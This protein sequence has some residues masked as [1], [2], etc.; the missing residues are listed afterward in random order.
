MERKKCSH[1]SYETNTETEIKYHIESVH[2]A[3][4][5]DYRGIKASGFPSGH[6]QWAAHR[7]SNMAD[8]KCSECPSV[9]NLES[10][11]NAHINRTHNSNFGHNCRQCKNVFNTEEEMLEHIKKTHNTQNLENIFLK[12]SDQI[13]TISQRLLSLEQ[14]SMTNF[15]NLGPQL[16]KK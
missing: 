15:P 2:G 14:R 5:K 4:K 11:L 7:N 12:I 13:D 3:I 8:Y 10:M 9:F 1:C 16:V 6:P